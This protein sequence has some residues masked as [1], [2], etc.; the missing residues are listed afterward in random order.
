MRQCR[1]F[2]TAFYLNHR[3]K[4]LPPHQPTGELELRRRGALVAGSGTCLW[5][6]LT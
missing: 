5:V 1:F 2:E 4:R 6:P 3:N